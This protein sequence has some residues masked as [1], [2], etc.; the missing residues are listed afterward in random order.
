[1]AEILSHARAEH[2]LLARTEASKLFASQAPFLRICCFADPFLRTPIMC[3]IT[4][5]TRLTSNYLYGN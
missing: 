4:F 3:D 2:A 5:V 1:M